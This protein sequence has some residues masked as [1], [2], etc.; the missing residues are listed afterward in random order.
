MII[1]ILGGKKGKRAWKKHFYIHKPTSDRARAI[2]CTH[3]RIL[4][5]LFKNTLSKSNGAMK[6]TQR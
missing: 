4:K 3:Y 1:V 6:A 5:A 2:D